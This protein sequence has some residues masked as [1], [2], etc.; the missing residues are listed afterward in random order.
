MRQWGGQLQNHTITSDLMRQVPSV[1]L[2]TF[3]HVL[4]QTGPDSGSN[5][6]SDRTPCRCETHW[7]T[8]PA[9][10]ISPNAPPHTLPPQSKHQMRTIRSPPERSR[11]RMGRCCKGSSWRSSGWRRPRRR[12][13]S[14]TFPALRSAPS[15]C[16]PGAGSRTAG[17]RRRQRRRRRR[18]RSGRRLSRQRPT[19]KSNRSKSYWGL[20]TRKTAWREPWIDMVICLFSA[21][22][23]E[24]VNLWSCSRWR[25]PE[26]D[27]VK[28][29]PRVSS[30][31]L[32]RAKLLATFFLFCFVAFLS[33]P[34]T[35]CRYF[36]S[37]LNSR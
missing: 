13:G 14:C 32:N 18:R 6:L 35:R 4:T 2:T 31:I 21:F 22:L 29:L 26:R 15:G 24:C 28:A 19:W 34:R 7:W 17:S 23:D 8:K 3:L 36:N 33:T 12:R 27:R 1:L 37:W 10:S 16:S 5:T 11:S 25:A 20:P 30:S 9:W